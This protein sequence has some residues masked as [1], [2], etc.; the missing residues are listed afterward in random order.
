MVEFGSF[1]HLRFISVEKL[2]T[3]CK[4]PGDSQVMSDFQTMFEAAVQA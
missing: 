2:A 3:W 4:T 1:F